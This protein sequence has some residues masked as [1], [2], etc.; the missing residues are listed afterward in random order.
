MAVNLINRE[1]SLL[2]AWLDEIFKNQSPLTKL[3]S[4]FH[5]F[6]PVY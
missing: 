5:V 6:R 2:E 1:E 3:L 4:T